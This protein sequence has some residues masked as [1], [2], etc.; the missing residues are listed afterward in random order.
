LLLLLTWVVFSVFQASVNFLYKS[1]KLLYVKFIS[2]KNIYRV[3]VYLTYKLAF[4]GEMYVCSISVIK[5]NKK[6]ET[7]T[8]YDV[9]R[10]INR[11]WTYQSLEQSSSRIGSIYKQCTRRSLVCEYLEFNLS[12]WECGGGWVK[13]VVSYS[14]MRVV[15][16][17][18]H[19]CERVFELDL[20]T[21]LRIFKIF[22]NLL[23]IYL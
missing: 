19:S 1:H 14:G 8:V 12:K 21:N 13:Q 4:M 16:I 5:K 23:E 7:S 9:L 11:C 15:C 22:F 17:C 2:D 20:R 6:K 18:L 10:S 3:F